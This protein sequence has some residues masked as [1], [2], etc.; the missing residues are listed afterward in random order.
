MKT[1]LRR[2]KTH[3]SILISLLVIVLALIQILP[4]PYSLVGSIV[5]AVFS[6]I[7]LVLSVQ[8]AHR[9]EMVTE[10]RIKHVYDRTPEGRQKQA[11][12]Q[13]GASMRKSGEKPPGDTSK[14]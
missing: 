4:F 11:L 3:P 2:I 5:V 8:E 13:L 9:D 7:A 12:E 6:V 10:A 14:D 1:F